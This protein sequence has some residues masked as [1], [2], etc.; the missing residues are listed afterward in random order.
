[1]NELNLKGL[2]V[3]VVGMGRSGLAA[4]KLLSKQGAHPLI[5]DDRPQGVPSNLPSSVQ[6]HL[7]NWHEADLTSADLI[8]LSPGVPQSRLPITRLKKL[9][10]P[11]ISEVELAA[12]LLTAPMI[13]ITGTNGKSTTTVLVGEILKHWGWKTF[14][15]GNLGLPLSEAVSSPWDFIVAELSSFQLETITHLHPRLSVL[16]NISADHL[17]RYDNLQA[18]KEAKWRIFENQTQ[19]DHAIL[20]LDDPLSLPLKH[21]TQAIYFSQTQAVERGVY[22]QDGEIISSLWGEPEIICHLEDLHVTP[23]CH[24]ENIL[25]ACAVTLLAGCSIEAISETLRRF[26]GLPH[27]MEFVREYRGVQYLNDSKGTNVVAVKRALEGL[28][29]PVTLIVGGRD[30]GSDFAE[31]KAIVGARVNHLILLGETQEK[32]AA[33]FSGHEAI[34]QVDTMAAAV[35]SAAAS[36]KSGEIVLLSP[37]C[38]SFDLFHD[39]QER[40]DVFKEAVMGLS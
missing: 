17:D 5:I 6:F 15:G 4:A 18:Y 34:E 22:L 40:G 29:K 35:E 31:L 26:K 27:R 14:V 33:V 32:M 16:L 13:A 7:G 12:S 21:N 30:K 1:M 8:V 25:A 37:A 28:K 39:Y 24:P 38:A 20:N 19:T 36:A 23:A 3:T 10:I 11:I 9:G 2:R